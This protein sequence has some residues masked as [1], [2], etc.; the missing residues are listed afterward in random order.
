M[1]FAN[2]ELRKDNTSITSVGGMFFSTFF[3]GDDSGWATP[4][5]T[6]TYYRNMQLYAGTGAADGT[7]DKI[8]GASM[9][10]R[11]SLW[12]VG[13]ALVVGWWCVFGV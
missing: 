1:S 13:S 11:G 10:A 9:A 6:Y 3:G 8:S 2:L 12:M 5:T 7:G 4:V